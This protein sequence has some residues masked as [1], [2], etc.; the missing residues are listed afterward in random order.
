MEDQT[1]PLRQ[2]IRSVDKDAVQCFELGQLRL[3]LENRPSEAVLAFRPLWA[4]HRQ[5]VVD[6]C[7]LIQLP[8]R[9]HFFGRGPEKA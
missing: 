1:F 8:R 6:G 7:I 9:G 2:N 5:F 3:G 4:A